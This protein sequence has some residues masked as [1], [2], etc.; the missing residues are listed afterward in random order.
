MIGV[1][2]QLKSSEEKCN[3]LT[4]PVNTNIPENQ[5]DP[6]ARDDIVSDF[7]GLEEF[8]KEK[9][10]DGTDT[11]NVSHSSQSSISTR[12]ETI[13]KSFSIEQ[14]RLGHKTNI[15]QFWKMFAQR[16]VYRLK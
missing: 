9:E 11:S 7:D 4:N 10:M 1:W 15:L 8:L 6:E 3:P 2:L 14:N 13:L 5:F 16:F 12:I